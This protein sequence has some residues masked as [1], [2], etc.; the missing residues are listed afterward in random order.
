MELKINICTSESCKIIIQDLTDDY[1]R[2]R[3]EDDISKP[4]FTD[5]KS[6]VIIQKITSE[7]SSIVD[8]QFITH[9]ENDVIIK[10]I[11]VGFD[12][13]FKV[14]YL[15]I[16]TIDWIN[17]F[18]LSEIKSNYTGIYFTNNDNKIYKVSSTGQ[19]QEV[20]FEEIMERNTE[21]TTI[22]RY[23]QDNL[24]IC[25]LRKCYQDILNKIFNS[26]FIGRCFTNNIDK[27]LTFKRD[28]LWMAINSLKYLV[29]FNQF[30]EAQR[31]LERLTSCNG[32]CNNN[33]TNSQRNGCGCM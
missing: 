23:V 11:S 18:E 27:D 8:T 6:I 20:Q 12:G 30:A 1:N 19:Y 4:K 5:T 17:K 24:S 7:N 29:E 13:W 14:Y 32:L 9:D 33:L 31:L 3:S 2:E 15:I 26:N 25:N 16:P 22:S 21:D 10:D 28:L